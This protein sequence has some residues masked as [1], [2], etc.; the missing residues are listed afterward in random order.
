VGDVVVDGSRAE[1]PA[2]QRAQRRELSIHGS[3]AQ[4]AAF[5]A[6]DDPFAQVAGRDALRVE[7]GV[8]GAEPLQKAL[9]VAAVVAYR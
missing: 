8:V 2:E 3:G 7:A 1:Q 4:C 6:V 5:R 9:D